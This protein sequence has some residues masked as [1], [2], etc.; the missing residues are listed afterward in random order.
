MNQK[1]ILLLFLIFLMTGQS[2]SQD[3]VKDQESDL[4]DFNY[5]EMTEI[6]KITKEV[7]K[8]LQI[9][10]LLDRTINNKK[11][12]VNFINVGDKKKEIYLTKD[13]NQTFKLKGVKFNSQRL[14]EVFVLDNKNKR[15][16]IVLETKSSISKNE[17]LRYFDSVAL[18]GKKKM[19]V[20]NNTHLCSSI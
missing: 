15:S 17:V 1:L 10:I 5:D 16:S 19:S 14:D 12:Q 7:S 4:Y 13:L 8:L 6:E 9:N 2:Y 11:I 20:L 18:L 3:L